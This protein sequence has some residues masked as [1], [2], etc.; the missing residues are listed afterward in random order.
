M[1]GPVKT[2]IRSAGINGIRTILVIRYATAD[3]DF[4]IELVPPDR[5]RFTLPRPH[6]PSYRDALAPER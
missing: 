4:D 3:S 5:P 2:H 6:V 1:Q